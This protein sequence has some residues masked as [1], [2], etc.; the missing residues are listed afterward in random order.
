MI[1]HGQNDGL[2]LWEDMGCPSNKLVVGVPL[3]GRTFTLSASNNNYNP[4]TYINKEAGGGDPGK[5]TGAKGFLAYY[6]VFTCANFF[7]LIFH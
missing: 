6:E 4:G 2:Q 5:Y 3:Y 7:F 1:C